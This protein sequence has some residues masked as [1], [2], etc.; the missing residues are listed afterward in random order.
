MLAPT[1]TAPCIPA[2][3]SQLL[4]ALQCLSHC[5]VTMHLGDISSL[6]FLVDDMDK[7]RE[8]RQEH[9]V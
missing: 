3:P 6:C 4:V 9:G 7:E 5:K 1:G 2:K 8:A